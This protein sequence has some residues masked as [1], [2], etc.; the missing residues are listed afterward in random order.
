MLRI[1]FCGLKNE[2]GN[3]KKGLSFEHKHFF[4]TLQNMPGV[5]VQSFPF[6]EIMAQVGREEMNNQ[7]IRRVEVE[8]PDLLFCFLFT[9][10]IKKETISHITKNTKTKTFNW[11]GDDHWRFPIF[12]RFWAPLFTLVSTTDGQAYRKY[13]AAGIKNIIKTQWAANN[14]LYSPQA[15]SLNNGKYFITFYGQKYGNRGD[16]IQNLKEAGL[17]AEGIGRGWGNTEGSDIQEMLNIYSFSKINLNFT[18]T[19]Y[20]GFKKKMNLLA[21]LFLKKELGHYKF[22]GHHLLR[23]AQAASGTQRRTIKART[24]EVP[25]CGGFLLTG[26]SD[27]PIEEYYLPGKEIVVFKTIS[28]LVEKCQYYLEH[29]DERRSIAAAG[30]SRTLD[31]HTYEHRFKEIFKALELI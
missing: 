25:A 14:Y 4:G 10:E 11:F 2:Y 7:L 13:L 17:P 5:E 6:D 18:E 22:D 15:P 29:E 26:P 31:Q 20:Y 23:N 1:L 30:L 27:D 16:Y 3:A 24:F 19:P 8:K 28:E 12:S 9:D 21:K